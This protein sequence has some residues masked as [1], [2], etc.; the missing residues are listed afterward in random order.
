MVKK[1]RKMMKTIVPDIDFK[2][3]MLPTD[4]I[5]QKNW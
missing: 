2:S 4:R 5:D 1:D 3:N